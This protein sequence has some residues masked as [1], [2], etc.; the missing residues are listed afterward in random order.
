MPGEGYLDDASS[1]LALSLAVA[2]LTLPLSRERA[3]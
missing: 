3:E 1:L 2:S